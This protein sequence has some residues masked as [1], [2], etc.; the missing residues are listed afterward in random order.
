MTLFE[1]TIMVIYVSR[2]RVL[3]AHDGLARRGCC[4]CASRAPSIGRRQRLQ[5]W[6]LG[7]QPFCWHFVDRRVDPCIGHLTTETLSTNASI[8]DSTNAMV[9][10]HLTSATFPLVRKRGRWW[11]GGVEGEADVGQRPAHSSPQIVPFAD[12]ILVDAVAY[13]SV[14]TVRV[15]ANSSSIRRTASMATGAF[16]NSASSKNFLRL[17]AQQAASTIRPG[18]RPS[19]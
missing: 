8:A 5:R 18:L 11:S 4:Q 9:G 10:I 6:S 17:W 2:N 3:I 7:D 12:P 13:C 1:I 19:T 15:E 16:C 14:S